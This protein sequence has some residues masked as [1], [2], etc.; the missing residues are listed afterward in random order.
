VARA[1]V[2]RFTK[3]QLTIVPNATHGV[4]RGSA[5]ARKMIRAFLTDPN[6]P[7]D[8]SCLHPEHDKFIFDL[9]S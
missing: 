5:C 7:I 2:G 3:G 6:A 8:Q 1:A 9:A 4:S